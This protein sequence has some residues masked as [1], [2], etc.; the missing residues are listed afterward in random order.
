M[1]NNENAIAFEEAKQEAINQY[2]SILEVQSESKD[3]VLT[4]KNIR[5][6]L[7]YQFPN[8]KFVVRK[9]GYKDIGIYWEDGVS[10]T[11]V[12]NHT[13]KFLLES[14][15]D[16]WNDDLFDYYETPFTELFGGVEIISLDRIIS[17][18]NKKKIEDEVLS[19]CP[20]LTEE[21]HTNEVWKAKGFNELITKYPYIKTLYWFDVHSVGRLIAMNTSF[22]ESETTEE[23]KQESVQIN[24]IS[25][26]KLDMKLVDYSDKSF[27]VIGN[28]KKYKDTLKSLGGRFNAKLACGAGW[29][30]PKSKSEEVRNALCF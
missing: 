14:R 25:S 2:G 17:K 28:T 22:G 1:R 24:I 18:E 20:S 30:F 11:E 29:I 16:K 15:R 6:Y 9:I 26:N 8:T 12:E 4:G 23:D 19:I 3:T 7:K 21:I 10:K 5:K 27:A 13:K